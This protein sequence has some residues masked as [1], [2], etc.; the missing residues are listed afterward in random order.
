MDR[1]GVEGIGKAVTA[2][3]IKKSV[4]KALGNGGILMYKH[5]WKEGSRIKAD[6]EKAAEV[7]EMLEKSEGL[8]AETLLD[9]SRDKDSPLHN[10][11]EWDN[12]L[13]AEQYRLIQARQM[14]RSLCV[15]IVP[16]EKA[17]TRA[18]FKICDKGYEQTENILKVQ[19]KRQSLLEQALAELKAFRRKYSSLQELSKVFEDIDMMGEVS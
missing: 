3:K 18:Y 6:P 12:N 13:A 7:F 11:F 17:V 8:T 19:A 1:Q 14:I 5:Y 9:V 2:G 10:C 15:E 16:E 4:Y